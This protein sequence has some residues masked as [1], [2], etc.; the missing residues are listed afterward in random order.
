MLFAL[1][2]RV[3][4]I[5]RHLAPQTQWASKSTLFA[6]SLV[7]LTTVFCGSISQKR[8]TIQ[9]PLPSS[10]SFFF[11]ERPFLSKLFFYSD[12]NLRLTIFNCL[13]KVK[14]NNKYKLK[15]VKQ[16]VVD[17]GSNL[18]LIHCYCFMK[19]GIHESTL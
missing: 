3:G 12:Q 5:K 17:V 15:V 13:I 14:K 8:K 9:F 2:K 6:K 18:T 1:H 4:G 19:V 7:K 10:Y 16:S 11:G